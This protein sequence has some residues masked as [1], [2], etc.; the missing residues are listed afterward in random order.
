MAAINSS[1]Q[2]ERGNNIDILT[3][4]HLL[5]VLGLAFLARSL[6]QLSHIPTHDSLQ[7]LC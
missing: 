6:F 3:T 4:A 1:Q 5:M 7:R 2:A